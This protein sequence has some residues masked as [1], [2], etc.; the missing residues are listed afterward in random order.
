MEIIKS[1]LHLN[2]NEIIA[3]YGT[4][5]YIILFIIIFCETGLV[6]TPFLPGDS[7]LFLVG[8]VAAQGS[9]NLPT[10]IILLICAAFCGDNTNYF[11]GRFLGPKIF[12]SDKIKL[13]NRKHLTRTQD[14]YDKHGGKTVIMA[15]F[16]PIIRTFAP[17][18]AGIGK[19][20]YVR[21]ISFSIFGAIAWTS[22]CTIAG[23]F[24][25]NIPVVK[26]NFELVI[27][28]IILISLLPVIIGLLKNRKSKSIV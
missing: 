19:M 15:R 27:I 14:F 6:V 10:C 11:L 2:L 26:K 8:T 3:H 21:F 18:V 9:L 28:M 24:M 20:N 25:G 13:L 4:A 22:L 16:I 17:F 23:Y 1:I 5:T 7:L 12:Y